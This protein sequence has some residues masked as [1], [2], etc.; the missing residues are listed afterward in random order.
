MI[1]NRSELIH[2]RFFV[3]APVRILEYHRARHEQAYYFLS[4]EKIP[5]SPRR[6][7]EARRLRLSGG[8]KLR[9]NRLH[10][11]TKRTKAKIRAPM[12]APVFAKLTGEGL[13]RQ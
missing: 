13:I 7:A 4:S 9:H 1:K 10:A 2:Q 5:M 8:E 12:L 6:A 3:L 11:A